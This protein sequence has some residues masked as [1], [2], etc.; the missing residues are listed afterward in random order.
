MITHDKASKSAAIVYH[1][2]QDFSCR[3]SAFRSRTQKQKYKRRLKNTCVLMHYATQISVLKILRLK[4]FR[5]LRRES[6]G[7]RPRGFL[8]PKTL[9]A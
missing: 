3:N 7:K 6:V 9:I 4:H 8:A 2:R 1:D 5:L